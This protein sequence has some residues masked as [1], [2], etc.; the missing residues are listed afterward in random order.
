MKSSASAVTKILFVCH[1]NICRSPMAEMVMK[2]FVRAAGKENSFFI[3]SAATDYDEI[4]NSMH[5]GTRNMLVRHQIPFTDHKARIVTTGDYDNFDLIVCM[6]DEN[7]RHLA[8]IVG[9]DSEKKVRKLLEFCGLSC[10]V[11]DPWYTG[12]FEETYSDVTA[13]CAALLESLL[14]QNDG[15]ER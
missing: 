12:N 9:R 4:G 1:G 6:D 2:H 7:L 14:C 15:L 13:G 3:D 11:A 5:R 10:D 8:R